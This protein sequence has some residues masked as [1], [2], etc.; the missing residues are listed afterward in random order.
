MNKE[1]I[2]SKSRAENKKRDIFELEVLNRASKYT[3]FVQVT[4]VAIFFITQIF[5]GQGINWGLWSLVLIP[6]MMT[7]WF[8]YMKLGHSNQIFIAFGYTILILF[9]AGYQIYNLISMSTVL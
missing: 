6:N 5:V 3:I 7:S 2:L 9:M 8:K 4:F 1:E